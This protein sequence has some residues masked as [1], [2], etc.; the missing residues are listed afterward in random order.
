MPHMCICMHKYMHMYVYMYMTFWLPYSEARRAEL[1]ERER[2]KKREP[3]GLILPIFERA[4]CEARRAEQ[5]ERERERKRE[6]EAP[7]FK[8]TKFGLQTYQVSHLV[9]KHAK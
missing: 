8:L 7:T 1:Y 2:E 3:E 4:G 6:R 5:Y 9:C